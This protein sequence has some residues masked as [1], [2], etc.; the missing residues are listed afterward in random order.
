MQTTPPRAARPLSPHLQIYK[1][2]LTSVLSI[3]HR[4]SGAY[5]SLCVLGIISWIYGISMG[6][7][8]FYAITGFW[9]GFLGKLIV[10][11]WVVS[12]AYHFSN[13]IRH[14]AW[15]I[16][17]GFELTTAYRTGKLVMLLTIIFSA[18]AAIIIF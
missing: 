3:L 9:N 13:G 1:P 4:I 17:W 7:D 11:S 2:Q 12:F 18:L 14:L 15:D 10:F 16:G 5:L 8:S 6:A